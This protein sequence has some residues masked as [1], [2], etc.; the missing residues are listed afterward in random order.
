LG[1]HLPV[2]GVAQAR[3]NVTAIAGSIAEL[4]L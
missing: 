3:G 2:I 4:Q 1:K